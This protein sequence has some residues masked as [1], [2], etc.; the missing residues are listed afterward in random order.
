MNANARLLAEQTNDVLGR[1][2]QPLADFGEVRFREQIC[3]P[4]QE[5]FSTDWA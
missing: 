5:P 4:G 2:L 3:K 1:D